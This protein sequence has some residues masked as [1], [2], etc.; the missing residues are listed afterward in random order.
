MVARSG[1]IHSTP[2]SQCFPNTQCFL[3][4]LLQH[5]LL[6]LPK[7]QWHLCHKFHS[8]PQVLPTLKTK[9]HLHLS[10]LHFHSCHSTH[11]SPSTLCFSDLYHQLH[12]LLIRTLLLL[13]PNYLR[14]SSLHS[15]CFPFSH[16][17]PWYLEFSI[18]QPL[19]LLLPLARR[20]W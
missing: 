16:N 3:G 19:R 12:L 7:V 4:P 5:T 2:S 1:S 17:S 14:Y 18:Q 8:C 13:R 9:K 10:T 6:P 15:I 20:L 11:S